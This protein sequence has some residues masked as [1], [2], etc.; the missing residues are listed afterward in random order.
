VGRSSGR[1]WQPTQRPNLAQRTDAIAA[2]MTEAQLLANVRELAG[3]LGWLTY[4]THRSDRSEA[5]FPDLVLVRRGRV[6]FAEL[7]DA[8]RKVTGDQQL[9]LDRLGDVEHVA[10]A[11]VTVHVWRPAD[12]LSGLI[13]R[14]LRR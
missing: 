9:W 12:W 6:I 14:E 8:T 4:H 1:P 7:K 3:V 11:A 5:G 10:A 2:A 13:E